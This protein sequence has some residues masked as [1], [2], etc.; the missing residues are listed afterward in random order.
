MTAT[1][2]LTPAQTAPLLRAALESIRAEVAAAPEDALRWRPA[3]AEWCALEVI[4]HLIETEQRG[5]AGRVRQ[6]LESPGL[7][8]AAWDQDAVAAARRDHERDARGLLDEFTSL[9]TAAVDLVTRLTAA[10][11]DKHGEHPK[12]GRLRIS[13]LLHEWVHHDR[14]HMR[15][16]LANLQAYVWPHMGNAQRF[17][18][19]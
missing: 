13:D 2:M 16:M 19:G 9:R 4:G 12:V 8:L 7:A 10:D 15:Q 14:N 18:S 3:P 17:S 1:R 5:F 11:L 6:I